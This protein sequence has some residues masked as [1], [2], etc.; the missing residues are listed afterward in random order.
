MC[1][2]NELQARLQSDLTAAMKQR[3]E[4]RTAA[5]RMA[6]AAL[7]TEQTAGKAARE[8]SDDEVVTVLARESKKRREAAEAFAAAGREESAARERAEESVLAQYL[9]AALG[10]EELDRIVAD[11][12]A[13]A[14]DSGATGPKAMGAVMK[15]VQPQVKGRAD[16]S[17]IAAKVRT[18]L[19][20]Q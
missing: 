15:A 8:L 4:L 9:P 13:M 17:V 2:V 10:D 1:V 20:S 5:L 14:A 11:A 6:L 18:A 16:G 19:Q 3:D 7:S 12:V